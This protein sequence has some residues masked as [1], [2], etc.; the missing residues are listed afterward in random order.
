MTNY[1]YP[2]KSRILN[3]N[4]QHVPFKRE[5]NSIVICQECGAMECDICGTHFLTEE[6]LLQEYY[7]KIFP[8]E[9]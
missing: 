4:C 2:P 1:I 5:D 6:F 8:E 7:K 9:Y 3:R